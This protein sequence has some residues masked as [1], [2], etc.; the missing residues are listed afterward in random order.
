MLQGEPNAWLAYNGF[1]NVLYHAKTAMHPE[2]RER[3]D[4][5][6]LTSVEAQFSLN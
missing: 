4:R 5:Q 3:I 1:N 6:I 2:Q